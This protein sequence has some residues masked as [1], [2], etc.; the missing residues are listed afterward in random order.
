[1]VVCQ[2]EECQ[3]DDLDLIRIEER[4]SDNPNIYD[5]YSVGIYKCK[6]C[7]ELTEDDTIEPDYNDNPELADKEPRECYDP[8]YASERYEEMILAKH[9]QNENFI[10]E[11]EEET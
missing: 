2:N 10:D 8:D 9:Y 7:G 11:E 6:F 4:K 5:P 3:S 1:M